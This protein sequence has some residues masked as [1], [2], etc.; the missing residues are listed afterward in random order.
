MSEVTQTK[1]IWGRLPFTKIFEVV[2]HL[3]KY[4]RSSSIYKNIWGR[5]PFTKVFLFF[6][7]QCLSKDCLI[8]FYKRCVP[9]IG[10]LGQTT[11]CHRTNC[12][13]LWYT[14]LL[15]VNQAIISL[16]VLDKE[17]SWVSIAWTIGAL[18]SMHC[19]LRIVFYACTDSASLF[20]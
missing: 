17:R 6:K 13:L 4:L 12:T 7:E 2:F 18:Y 11:V 14:P 5:L 15:Q 19:I 3:Q 20:V 8:H 9:P 1:D 10:G 16:V